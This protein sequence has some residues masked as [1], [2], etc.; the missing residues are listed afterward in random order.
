[1]T[2]ILWL[3]LVGTMLLGGLIVMANGA[4]RDDL[5]IYPEKRLQ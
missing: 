2:P 3:K 4:Y 1:M 5:R